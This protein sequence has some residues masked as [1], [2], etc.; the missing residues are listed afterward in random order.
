SPISAVE[1]HRHRMLGALLRRLHDWNFLEYVRLLMGQ[2]PLPYDPPPEVETRALRAVIEWEERLSGYPRYT[3]LGEKQDLKELRDDLDRAAKA[4]LQQLQQARPDPSRPGRKPDT[5][6]KGDK[7]IADAW[8]TGKHRT[9]AECAQCL[10]G[11]TA[12]DVKRAI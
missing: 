1:R 2:Q 12:N 6:P 11:L 10:G 4:R 3:S 7:R 9:Y 8:R 5:D